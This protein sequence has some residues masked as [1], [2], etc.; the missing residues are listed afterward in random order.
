MKRVAL[1]LILSFNTTVAIAG[2]VVLSLGPDSTTLG[3]TL[4]ATGHDV[5][6]TLPPASGELRFDVA[7]GTVGG[8]IRI[9]ATGI[10]S[11]HKK[12]DKTMHKK[13][14]ESATYPEI[15][16]RPERMEGALAVPGSST[17]TLHG[18]VSIH[19]AEHPLA[20]PA[21]IEVRDGMFE[22]KATFAVPYVG[23][24]HEGSQQSC[25]C[26]WPRRSRSRS[27]FARR[28]A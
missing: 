27:R 25:S 11:G 12:R 26:G 5:A 14:L 6:G 10:E 2:E 24:G 22:A 20:V 7:T 21:E 16:F 23:L 19:G 18:V 17:V 8:E 3:F 9:D 4:G 15:V 13:V 1:A 28:S